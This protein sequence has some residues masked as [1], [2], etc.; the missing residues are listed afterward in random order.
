M[1]NNRPTAE[2][3]LNYSGDRARR[4]QR[5]TNNLLEVWQNSAIFGGRPI[6]GAI[7]ALLT[8]VVTGNCQYCQLLFFCCPPSALLLMC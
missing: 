7:E 1:T 4:H 2:E 5:L 8:K 3:Q 6:G